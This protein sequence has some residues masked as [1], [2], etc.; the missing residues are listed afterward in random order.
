MKSNRRWVGLLTMVFLT[1]G[2]TAK[3]Q[4]FGFCLPEHKDRCS[5]DFELIN[6]LIIIPVT[7]NDSLTLNFILDTGVKSTILTDNSLTNFDLSHCRPVQILGA[8]GLNQVVAYVVQ[9]VGLSVGKLSCKAMNFVVLTE[10]FLKLQNHLGMPVHGILGYDFFNPFVVKINYDRKRVVVYRAEA[11]KA[12]R[13][14]RSIAMKIHNGRPYLPAKI[15][16]RDGSSIEA[17]LLLDSG[18]SHALMLETDSD[19][20]ITIPEKNISTIVGWGLS[21]ELN[22]SMARIDSLRIGHLHFHDVL[23]TYTA[24]YSQTLAERIPGRKGS[25]GGELLSRYTLTLDYPNERLYYRKSSNFRNEFEYNLGGPD[26]IASGANFK[27]YKVI[28]I[29]PHSPA[30]KAGLR[31][32]DIVLSI[33]GQMITEMSIQEVNGFFRSK[34]KAKIKLLVLRD[35]KLEMISFRLEKMI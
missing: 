26:M 4:S 32:D 29:I 7:V 8:G 17:Q 23:T 35:Q 12:P 2:Q 9:D 19:S 14:H 6:N 31:I 11:F 28:H 13:R 5:F 18:A 21:G 33:N 25:I 16:Q 30:E 3:S 20:L 24:G 10:D 27:L 22:G 1:F 34:P 15:C